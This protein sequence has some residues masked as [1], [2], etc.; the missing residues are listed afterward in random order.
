MI[1]CRLVNGQWPAKNIL[2][3][4]DNVSTVEI[5]NKKVDPKSIMKIM[6]ILTW[7]PAIGNVTVHAKHIASVGRCHF[8][9]TDG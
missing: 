6:R 2:L 7:C 1:C 4:C 3:H 5:I 9:F 8:S